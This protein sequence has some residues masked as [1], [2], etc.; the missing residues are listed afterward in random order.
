M[1][2]TVDPQEIQRKFERWYALQQKLLQAQQD[3]VEAEALLAEVQQ[4]YLSPQWAQD[5]ENDVAIEHSGETY[6]IFSEDGIWNAM[7]EHQEQAIGWMRLGLDSID[8]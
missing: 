5:R 4:Y 6:S 1:S 7:S 3:W 2:H 8:K